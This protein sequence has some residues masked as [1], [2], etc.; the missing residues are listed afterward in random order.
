MRSGLSVSAS[1][2]WTVGPR[3]AST[4]TNA[5]CSRRATSRSTGWRKPWAGSSKARPKA[6]PGRLTRTSW[7]GA[8][9]LWAPNARPIVTSTMKAGYG[10]R[11]PRVRGAAPGR[12]SGRPDPRSGFGNR[13]HWPGRTS[14]SGAPDGHRRPQ[15]AGPHGRRDR[16]GHL[17][18]LVRGGRA[19][20]RDRQRRRGRDGQP[21]D[22]QRRLARRPRTLARHHPRPRGHPSGLDRGRPGLGDRRGDVARGRTAPP[23]CVRAVRRP[24]GP[25]LDADEPDLLADARTDARPG[26]PLRRPR[27]EHHRQVPGH[28]GRHRGHGRGDA[29]AG[30]TSTAR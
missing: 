18:R 20:V 9:M 27:P 22:R 24:P 26:R 12:A 8:V 21:D 15:P 13:L 4:S 25:P 1:S 28:V 5:S 3:L 10:P 23:A 14:R 6:A 7:S 19:R 17:E 30:S 29:I 11:R 16:H 2:T